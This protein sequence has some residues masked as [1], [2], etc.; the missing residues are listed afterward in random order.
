MYQSHYFDFEADPYDK[1]NI[2]ELEAD[3]DMLREAAEEFWLSMV[4]H[5]GL[6][7]AIEDIAGG[8]S[9]ETELEVALGNTDYIFERLETHD[10]VIEIAQQKA[11]AIYKGE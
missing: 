5:D 4:K 11:I 7:S 3:G 6:S 9:E 8:C 2:Q 10:R 1:T